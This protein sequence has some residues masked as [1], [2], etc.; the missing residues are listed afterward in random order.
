MMLGD[1]DFF[2]QI[3]ADLRGNLWILFFVSSI[4]LSIV[5]VNILI[6]IIS[7]TYTKV[8]GIEKLTRNYE[9]CNIMYQIDACEKQN[10]NDDKY[11][12]YIY[13]DYSEYFENEN[14]FDKIKSLIKKQKK[15]MKNVESTLINNKINDQ[16]QKIILSEKNN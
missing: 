10:E 13:N 4:I 9:L 14:D 8:S 5:L 12:V 3:K 6:A 7:N 15:I 11:L 1:Y 16:K 2:D